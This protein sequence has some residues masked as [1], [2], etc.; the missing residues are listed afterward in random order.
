M[1]PTPVAS[2][3]KDDKAAKKEELEVTPF[4]AQLRKSMLTT[5]V[6]GTILAA[7]YI[8]THPQLTQASLAG[9]VGYHVIWGVTQPC[10]LD[11]WVWQMQ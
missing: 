3:K 2:K 5:G 6:L 8:S 7:G 11:R 10:T 1:Q 4:T 9:I